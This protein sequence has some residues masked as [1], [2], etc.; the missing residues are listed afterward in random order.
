MKKDLKV[1][2]LKGKLQHYAWGGV[3]FLP[4][5]LSVDNPERRPFAEYWL[6]AHENAP[7]VLEAGRDVPLN[8]YVAESPI[9]ALGAYTAGR[10]GRL[11]YLLKI[12]DV[13]DMLS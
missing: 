4:S 10:F 8:Q 3:A 11:P 6:G 12:L 2:K 13:K 7:A 5:L 9:D 1:F